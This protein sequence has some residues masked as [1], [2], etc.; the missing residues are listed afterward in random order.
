MTE[1]TWHRVKTKWR[2]SQSQAQERGEW[3]RQS[4]AGERRHSWCEDFR[5]WS[6]EWLLQPKLLL[7]SFL[8]WWTS[9]T[10]FKKFLNQRFHVT[11][12]HDEG[13]EKL[14]EA[15]SFFSSSA[16]SVLSSSKNYTPNVGL[17]NY[18]S[19]VFSD[20]SS[21]HYIRKLSLAGDVMWR[22]ED[23]ALSQ[24]FFVEILFLFTDGFGLPAHEEAAFTAAHCDSH[25]KCSVPC[26]LLICCVY[27]WTLGTM[28]SKTNCIC[29]PEDFCHYC[30]FLDAGLVCWVLPSIILI[31]TLCELL[32][33]ISTELK[34]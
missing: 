23:V 2:N 14:Q 33:L 1:T 29:W 30:W 26:V 4:R 8:N 24:V 16:S 28:K 17:V 19:D 9:S 34:F 25:S 7:V 32:N 10:C 6:D 22:L 31:Q 12:A 27:I 21:H 3:G 5:L 20:W 13:S 18:F 15:F 11:P